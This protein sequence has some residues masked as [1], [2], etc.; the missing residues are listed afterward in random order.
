MNDTITNVTLNTI[1]G[2]VF[3]IS[4]ESNTL[5]R[6]EVFQNDGCSSTIDIYHMD[7]NGTP[8]RP[9][10]LSSVC[11]A[12]SIF[13]IVHVSVLSYYTTLWIP[14][15]FPYAPYLGRVSW[16]EGRDWL[17]RSIIHSHTLE[18]G[19]PLGLHVLPAFIR[20]WT[21]IHMGSSQGPHLPALFTLQPTNSFGIF[22]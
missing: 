18:A 17:S 19:S 8:H 2:V 1:D 3:S 7:E 14:F 11:K 21:F 9:L 20:S 4:F 5:R 10:P 6:R 15:L 22:G 12:L 13:I 16:M